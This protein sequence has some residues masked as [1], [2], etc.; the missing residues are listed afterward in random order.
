MVKAGVNSSVGTQTKEVKLLARFLQIVI[1]SLY[2]LVFHQLMVTA[3]HIDLHQILIY[4]TSGTKI[5]VS[6]LGVTHL[7]VRK[8]Y[9]F[10]ASLKVGHWIFGSERIDER[11]ALRVYGVRLVMTAFSPTVKNHQKYFSVHFIYKSF[12]Y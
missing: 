8:T 4:D 6:Y 12:K 3:R 7:S 5:H 11:R 10:T 9:I 1:T 2:L